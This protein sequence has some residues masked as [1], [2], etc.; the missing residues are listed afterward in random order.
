MNT[1][2]DQ[3]SA[4]R[5]VWASNFEQ[6][7]KYISEILDK[8]P[9]IS[10]DTEFPGIIHTVSS[11][12]KESTYKSIK[13]NVDDLK[14]IQF[15]ITLCDEKGN[16]PP[17][18]S[19]WQF[20]MS[21]DIKNDKHSNDSINLLSN[22]GICFNKLSE[23]GICPDEF[24]NILT[25]SGLVLNEDIKWIAFHG[26]YDFAYLI[27]LLTNQPLPETEQGFFDILKVYFPVFYDIRHLTRN[28]EG[29]SKSLQKLAQELDIARVG[30][31]HQAGSDSLVTARV[32]F[33]ISTIYISSDTLKGDENVLFGLGAYYED[34][35]V[36]IFDSSN[37][38]PLNMNNIGS[39]N[40]M[41]NI[42][43]LGSYNS[44]SN[45]TSNPSNSMN[46]TA[47]PKIQ[48][49]YDMNSYFHPQYSYHNMGSNYYRGNPGSFNYS[50]TPYNPNFPYTLPTNEY[51]IT[52]VGTN[53]GSIGGINTIPITNVNQNIINQTNNEELKK[54][55]FPN[56]N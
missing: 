26:S 11:K 36:A 10:M 41:N 56:Q 31:Q 49:Q 5:E 52:G 20:N 48:T 14:L 37:M 19:T 22:S 43:N 25:T 8:Y 47:N 45:T 53:M 35:S 55:Q 6:E 7:M 16:S 28:L 17:E 27:K 54:R 46:I 24:G 12:L 30:T 23:F 4:I 29:F 42:N 39:I 2:K 33:K 38:I 40:N 3:S 44:T 50:Y 32:Y 9:Y 51:M 18:V 21:F 15:G 1:T 34:E 13:A